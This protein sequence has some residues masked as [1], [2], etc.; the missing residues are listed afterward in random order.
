MNFLTGNKMQNSIELR[1]VIEL[2]TRVYPT[3]ARCYCAK[4][5]VFLDSG[6]VKEPNLKYLPKEEFDKIND[7]VADDSVLNVFTVDQVLSILLA[8]KD[9]DGALK[10][11][12]DQKDKTAATV[13]C[14]GEMEPTGPCNRYRTPQN[15]NVQMFEALHQC[16]NPSCKLE[17]M[18]QRDYPYVDQVVGR[19]IRSPEELMHPDDVIKNVMKKHI[20]STVTPNMVED[21]AEQQKSEVDKTLTKG[22]R[23]SVKKKKDGL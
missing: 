10:Y 20:G 13:K 1:K 8:I 7:H 2:R 15:P 14:Y 18:L 5:A 21:K 9:F 4:C 22:K 16:N 11:F 6:Q 3:E 23:R 19:L 17:I 12:M